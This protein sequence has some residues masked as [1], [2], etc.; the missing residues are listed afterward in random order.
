MNLLLRGGVVLT[1]P[2]WVPTPLD[3]QVAEGRIAALGA[4]GT[5][6][7]EATL[8]VTDRL[9]MP[10]LV[11]GHTHSHTLPVR[12]VLRQATLEDSLLGAAWMAGPRPAELSELSAIIAATEMVAS[13]A[14]GAF[15]LLGQT[16][17]PEPEGLWAAARG[18]AS[19]G[20]RTVIA[21]MVADR[22]V[23]EAVPVIGEC[24][25]V[26]VSGLDAEEIV[27][28]TRTYVEGFP[29]LAGVGPAVAP[30][31]PAHCSAE[32]IWGLQSLAVEHGLRIHLHLAESKVQALA[33]EERFGHPIV[34]EL[35]R[36][37]VL[38]PR[39]T[40]AHG[41]WLSA[42]S[43]DALA[44]AGV[45][46]VT[47]PGS[48]LRL[49]SGVADV[50]GLLRAGVRIGIGTD[51]ANS[52]DLLDMLDAVRLTSLMSRAFVQPAADWLSVEET[53]TA[54]TE[55]GAAAC[56]W[57]DVGRIQAGYRADLTF[58]DLRARA[59]LPANDLANQVLTAARSG[60]VTDVMVGGRFVYQDRTFPGLDLAAI[61][62]RF[63]T[64]AEQW[65]A[66]VAGGV[67][68]GRT[69]VGEARA[70]LAAERAR[71]WEPR[72]LL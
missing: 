22:S 52:A 32:L 12:G 4:P 31:I 67:A 16:G 43:R 59:F 47:V 14:T 5:L 49:G 64:L 58:L 56:G 33:G 17:G 38:S 3:V 66:T 10:G 48:N 8:D 72:H 40:A 24:C 39:L 50:R 54:A 71:E 34:S 29:A 70:A 21:P 55:G 11:N 30:T 46:V 26:P 57:D 20:L 36:L 1:G 18:Y 28:R 35:A 23:H 15:D 53:L 41:I 69:Q 51:G 2:D 61:E 19:V 7:G 42:E 68:T 60:D 6:A 44:G 62:G 25:G 9:I 13:G 63:R 65:R 45:V 37:G 27:A